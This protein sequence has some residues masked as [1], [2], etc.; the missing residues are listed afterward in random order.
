MSKAKAMAQAMLAEGISKAWIA[1]EIGYGRS[2]VS[3]WLNEPDY[4]GEHIEG[5]FL[6]RFERR[7]CPHDGAEKQPQQCERIALQP[8]PHGF[9]DAAALWST[10]QSCQY[11]PERKVI[12]IVNK[13]EGKKGGVK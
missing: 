9:P 8:K 1:T 6:A 10:C 11:K 12:P 5:K 7:Y 13:K 2:A 4:Q 3:R